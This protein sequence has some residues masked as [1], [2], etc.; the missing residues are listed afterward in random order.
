MLGPAVPPTALLVLPENADMAGVAAALL[1]VA[2]V[3]P[4]AAAVPI[5]D[6]VGSAPLFNRSHARNKHSLNENT[7]CN[8]SFPNGTR[9]NVGLLL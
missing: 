8:S 7:F 9:E 5:F 6:L 4:F 1:V 3:A 2:A